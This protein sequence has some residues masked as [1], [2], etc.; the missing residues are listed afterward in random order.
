MENWTLDEIKDLARRGSFRARQFLRAM[1][2]SWE[3]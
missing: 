2:E 3:R 1:E